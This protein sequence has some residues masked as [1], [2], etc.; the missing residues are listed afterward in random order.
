[1][2]VPSGKVCTEIT[3]CNSSDVAARFLHSYFGLKGGTA[4]KASGAI[5]LHGYPCDQ[6]TWDIASVSPF[7]A[8]SIGVIPKGLALHLMAHKSGTTTSSIPHNPLLCETQ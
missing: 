1:M 8:N 4:T 2:N 7:R 3:A 6:S 5:M